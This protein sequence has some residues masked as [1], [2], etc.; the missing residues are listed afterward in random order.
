[1]PV[2]AGLLKN[3][4]GNIFLQP[5]GC[6]TD[7]ELLECAMIEDD[8]TIELGET[9][10]LYCRDKNGRRVPVARLS[11][12]PSD[13][14][15]TIT[16]Y[17]PS[18]ASW[19]DEQARREFCPFPLYI[20]YHCPTKGI[21]KNWTHV[22]KIDNAIITAHG[23]TS[24]VDQM[25]NDT[26]A[27]VM[28]TYTISYSPTSTFWLHR[29]APIL[30][31]VTPTITTDLADIA[32]LE[33]TETCLGDCE[34]TRRACSTGY[35]AGNGD[36]VTNGSPLVGVDSTCRTWSQIGAWYIG[37]AANDVGSMV[38]TDFGVQPRIVM[39]FVLANTVAI[40]DGYE[41][42]AASTVVLSGVTGGAAGPNAMF[43][44][45][46][47]VIWFALSGA[48]S[49]AY[50]E[51]NGDTW[52]ASTITIASSLSIHFDGTLN[53]LVGGTGG[54]IQETQNGGLSWNSLGSTGIAANDIVSIK[55]GGGLWYVLTS[56]G[57]LYTKPIGSN[58]DEAWTEITSPVP[59]GS[60]AADMDVKGCNAV[61]VYN[62]GGVGR[63][64][65]TVNGGADW[66]D[67]TATG[68]VVSNTGF[69]A[70][71]LQD[72]LEATIVGNAGTVVRLTSL[73]TRA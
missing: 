69:N 18:Q 59:A 3:S 43:L 61:L 62:T 58:L 56:A 10:T 47:G 45:E 49:V 36:G 26:D 54:L 20:A 6:A 30:Q 29:P 52:S 11:S 57:E 31:P 12:P 5:D 32:Y 14:S 28:R 64:S 27:A 51:D 40:A 73:P 55:S 16:T 15:F 71:Y 8:I 17:I 23:L 13:G 1:M 37:A 25:G 33:D 9:E 44:R 67:P 42:T 66:S 46:D 63:L 72:Y 39:G 65:F 21:F 41:P 4:L 34:D 2:Q 53:G 35:T 68:Q 7:M 70:V 19:L 48:N 24:V 60:V 38:A 50:S 22:L